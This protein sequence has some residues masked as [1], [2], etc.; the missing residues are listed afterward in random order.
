MKGFS[1]RS[2][3]VR[4]VL[5]VLLALSA[6]SVLFAG[7][8]RHNV[9]IV[10][11]DSSAVSKAI[12]EYYRAARNIPPANVC[13][14]NCTTSESISS[15]DFV[16]S[17]LYPIENYLTAHGL[18]EQIQYIVLTKGVPLQV[19]TTGNSV[20]SSLS[21]A[22]QRWPDGTSPCIEGAGSSYVAEE[23]DFGAF[24]ASSANT[25]VWSNARPLRDLAPRGDGTVFAVGGHFIARSAN[26]VD[27]EEIPEDGCLGVL[28]ALN[29]A[30][31]FDSTTGWAVGEQ[32]TILKTTDGGT[33]WQRVRGGLS[34]PLISLSGV[35]FT[36]A[37]NGWAVGR[38]EYG[39]PLALRS[40]DGGSTW[41]PLPMGATATLNDVFF[42]DSLNGWIVGDADMLR[43][44][45]G[46]ETWVSARNGTPEG[47]L[48]R[49]FFADADNGWV[50]GYA[51]LL[52]RTTDGGD[53][54]V[55]QPIPGMLDQ[56][57]Q[58]C[59]FIDRDTGW[60]VTSCGYDD[61][62]KTSW[63]GRLLR[64]TD[65]GVN[66]TTLQTGEADR[67]AV[68]FADAQTGWYVQQTSDEQPLE[69]VI[70]RSADGGLSRTRVYA[71]P[72]WIVK[73]MYL[74][75]RLDAYDEDARNGGNGVPDDVEGMISGSLAPDTTGCFVIDG[76]TGNLPEG[77]VSLANTAAE[78]LVRG[79]SVLLDQ[80]WTFVTGA[81]P[82][83]GSV[84][85]YAGWGSNDGCSKLNT[86][87]AKPGFTWKPGSIAMCYVSSDGRS[88]SE[89][90]AYLRC[91]SNSV[92]DEG[93]TYSDPGMIEINGW[94]Y[95]GW[96]AKLHDPAGDVISSAGFTEGSIF[97]PCAAPTDGYIQIYRPDGVTP[98]CGGRFPSSGTGILTGGK[99]YKF[100]TGQ[101]LIADYISE[102]C[103]A[104]VG[105]VSEPGFGSTF[106]EYTF[107]RYVD[108]YTWAESAWMG[109][110]AVPW[111]FI[112]VG[113]PLMSPYATPPLVVIT[114]PGSDGSVLKG[115][116][117][118]EVTATDAQGIARVELWVDDHIHSAAPGPGP[119]FHLSLDTEALV[120]GPHV[121]EAIAYEAGKVA[122]QAYSLRTVVTVNV[123]SVADLF[124]APDGSSVSLHDCIV[125]R[126]F[127]SAGYI[128]VQ[129]GQAAG[130][131][132]I[133]PEMPSE[134]NIVD[135]VGALHT[136][137]GVERWIDAETLTVTSTEDM[138]PRAVGMRNGSLGGKSLGSATGITKPSQPDGLY[139][140][141][142]L[143]EMWGRITSVGADYFYMSDG[144]DT[145]GI[146]VKCHGFA[147]PYAVDDYVRTTG[148]ST[149]D[150][151]FRALLLN[152]PADVRH[153]SP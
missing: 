5:T 4:L 14:I 12:G 152:K 100:S 8:G 57:L 101:S 106:P 30:F 26:G 36:S 145:T 89:P 37:T 42:T 107:P 150:A 40:T 58:D 112:A 113:D 6:C 103:S 33:T 75:C 72:P 92:V 144:S 53:T 25:V 153:L 45:D 136:G 141:G 49:V 54:W 66:W 134:G 102:G 131:K 104:A 122:T 10:V 126:T 41:T 132:V 78:L 68:H 15:A 16:N 119:A 60:I 83:I 118:V 74:V 24:R 48:T 69:N 38:D 125:S 47:S 76:S 56:T 87:W 27:W 123:D 130:I 77:N 17:I 94:V 139:N 98:V 86:E 97:L 99:A 84:A 151:G 128:Y 19:S 28:T 110:A 85:G 111:T 63:S 67:P 140:I 95:S 88:L 138:V 46:G 71:T 2:G 114:S 135:L 108:G 51:A 3:E 120:D 22:F 64:T 7:G 35:W 29:R 93:L 18:V 133:Y 147:P 81:Y 121:L 137:G 124:R 80:D 142:L 105:S 91:T 21:L 115:L 127:S 129:E 143:A 55:R 31:F 34:S 146:K 1:L 79:R 149:M 23:R 50:I 32:D 61:E 20:D 116:V 117:D 59:H 44:T 96:V 43:T 73:L 82:G 39:E 65:G 90:P 62:D 13:H 109:I 70:Y 9:L 11:N 148:I 52:C